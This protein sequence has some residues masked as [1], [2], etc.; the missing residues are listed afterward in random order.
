MTGRVKSTLV[1]LGTL[2]LG[3][4][5]GALGAGAVAQHRAEQ[6]RELR[7][8]E[9]FVAHMERLIAPRDSAQRAAIRPI[10]EETAR[11]NA[12]IF[13]DAHTRLGARMDTMRQ[14]LAPL[15]DAAQ[16]ARL[17]ELARRHERHHGPPHAGPG[18][19]P[20]EGPPHAGPPG[21]PDV[22]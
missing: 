13:Q 6:I 1:L 3:V 15:L 18:A 19:A 2:V 12:A 7:E 9:G 10:L 16:R 21:P 8:R 5:L 17:E 22:E 11:N 4:A 14:R 20:R